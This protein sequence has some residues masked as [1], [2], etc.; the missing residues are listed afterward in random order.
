M[1][2][3]SEALPD[4]APAA[5]LQIEAVSRRYGDRPAVDGVSWSARAGETVCLLGHSG[6]G[7]TTLLRLIAGVERPD[8]GS[9]HI[10]GEAMSTPSR[11]VPAERRRV[12]MVFQDYALFPHLD[13]LRNVVFGLHEGTRAQRAA[14]AQAAL[15]R[16]GLAA[17]VRHYPHM[18]SGGE[19][20]R[21]ALARALAPAPRVLLMDEPFSNLDRRLRDRVRDDTMA[22]LREAGITAVVVTHDPQEALCIADRIVLMHGGRVEQDAPPQMLYR[23]PASLF[24]AR[25]FSVLNEIPGE[26]RGGRIETALGSFDAAGLSDGP[27]VVGLRPRDVVTASDGVA[28]TVT[29]TLFLG[30]LTQL[31]VRIA[32]H[33]SPL[34]L[35]LPAPPTVRPGQVVHLRADEAAALRFPAPPNV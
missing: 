30:D 24:A 32:G 4:R 19:Q 26:V 33:A 25:F 7:K 31:R 22:L 28:G 15:E 17:R 9:I 27:A 20:Q 35:H 8:S 10:D 13:V 14:R 18:L 34:M 11:F 3:P 12:G 29:D 6:C 21:V 23:Q 1:P 16:V 5:S 2:P